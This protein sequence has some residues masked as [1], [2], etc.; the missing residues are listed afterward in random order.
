MLDD[1]F[2]L[3]SPLGNMRLP[4][5]IYFFREGDKKAI[6]WTPS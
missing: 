1:S 5:G 3:V 4:G 2:I 6:G